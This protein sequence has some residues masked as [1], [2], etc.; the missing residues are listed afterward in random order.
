MES[1]FHQGQGSTLSLLIIVFRLRKLL[2]LAG[3]QA[4]D[5]GGTLCGQNSRL[6]NRLPAKAQ[7]YISFFVERGHFKSAY[8]PCATCVICVARF[9]RGCN[10]EKARTKVHALILQ[11]PAVYCSP[12][13]ESMPV[14]Q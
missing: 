6:L 14:A 12:K 4:A 11:F 9:A 2:N 7:G 10:E 5:G 3:E 8:C 1:F 13:R